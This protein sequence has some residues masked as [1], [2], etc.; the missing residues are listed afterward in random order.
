MAFWNLFRG[1]RTGERDEAFVL[2]RVFPPTGRLGTAFLGGAPRLPEGVAWPTTEDGQGLHFL[3]QVDLGALPDTPARRLLPDGALLFFAHTGDELAYFDQPD[4][5]AVLHVTGNLAAIPPR[6]P[7]DDVP[8]IYGDDAHYHVPWVPPARGP[9]P[10]APRSFPCWNVQATG[11]RTTPHSDGPEVTDKDGI[12]HDSA[13]TAALWSAYR[14]AFGPPPLWEYPTWWEE[15][16]LPR[17]GN[18]PLPLARQDV[19][20][21]PD[22]TWPHAWINIGIFSARLMDK[23]RAQNKTPELE[24]ALAEAA[25][26]HAEGE[27]AGLFTAVPADQ[28]AAFR[29]WMNTVA[30]FAGGYRFVGLNRLTEQAFLA[31]ADALFGYAP[32]AAASLLPARLLPVLSGRHA[33]FARRRNGTLLV[34]HQLLGHGQSVQGAPERLGEDHLLLAQFDTDD[35]MFWMWGDVGVLQFWITP[36]DLAARRFDACVVTMEGH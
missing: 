17:L 24:R 3:G 9:S 32:E 15:K 34:R 27:R 21:L 18:H 30:P 10:S 36:A 11:L 31:G 19:A 28:R 5:S 4:R 6:E 25:A 33:A 35:G 1:A 14:A 2:R 7:P 23:L 29:A 22:E 26:W 8:P 16:D 13:S 20:W 12:K